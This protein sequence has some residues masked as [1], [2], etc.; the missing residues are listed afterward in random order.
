M[1]DLS[2]MGRVYCNLLY[3]YQHFGGASCL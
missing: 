2:L 1:E 3:I